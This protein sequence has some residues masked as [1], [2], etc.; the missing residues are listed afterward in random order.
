MKKIIICMLLL[1]P[2]SMSENWKQ[3][4]TSEVPVAG[5]KMGMTYDEFS[6]SPRFKALKEEM[7]EGEKEGGQLSIYYE[8]Y[9]GLKYSDFANLVFV[10]EEDFSNFGED[11]AH[12]AILR[13]SR[14][15]SAYVVFHPEKGTAKELY[16]QLVFSCKSKYGDGDEIHS[17]HS[18][19]AYGFQPCKELSI[20]LDLVHSWDDGYDEYVMLQ[21][22]HPKL[23]MLVRDE[24][25]TKE[26]KKFDL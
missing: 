26:S 25:L 16:E 19:K 8:S 17:L 5:L 11:P 21:L 24:E 9:P 10:A 15:V 13:N 18:E 14:L 20:R 4:A 2:F 12:T 23:Q 1:A 6:N 7:L 3:V 22:M